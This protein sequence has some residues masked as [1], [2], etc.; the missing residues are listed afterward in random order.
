MRIRNKAFV[1]KNFIPVIARSRKK[2]VDQLFMSYKKERDDKFWYLIKPGLND[3]EILCKTFNH[4]GPFRRIDPS[5]LGAIP[6]L[7]TTT[8][9]AR[10]PEKPLDGFT[11]VEKKRSSKRGKHVSQTRLFNRIERFVNM[12]EPISDDDLSDNDM[13]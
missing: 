12:G 13:E 5:I 7:E 9:K 4:N 2:Y 11:K 1:V 3:I 10:S 6:N 8:P